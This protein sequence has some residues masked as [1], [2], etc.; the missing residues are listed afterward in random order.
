M[1]FN[2]NADLSIETIF[3]I[4]MALFL[5]AILGYG[6]NKIFFIDEQISERELIEIQSD[7][8][9]M[10]TFCED[11]LNVG[12]QKTFKASHKSFNSFCV[13]GNKFNTSDDSTFKDIHSESVFNDFEKIY[14]G[15]DNVI[16]IN[17]RFKLDG[18][19]G[20]EPSLHQIVSSFNLKSVSDKSFCQYDYNNTGY[21]E[22]KLRCE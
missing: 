16:L 22:F 4:M 12:N 2:K 6:I 21:V 13:L 5:V 18:S 15:G 19:G 3:Y 8:K 1:I 14:E 17:T 20:Y 9:D 10:I 7:L 11:P